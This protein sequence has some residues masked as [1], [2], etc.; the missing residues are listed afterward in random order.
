[1]GK[2]G[3]TATSMAR[4]NCPADYSRWGNAGQPQHETALHVRQ[5]IIADGETRANRN[6]KCA[7]PAW[8]PIIADGETR[9][10]R[11]PASP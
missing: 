6:R 1:M 8:W 11:N 4:A 9:A 2:R 3:P 7:A 10:N 5:L